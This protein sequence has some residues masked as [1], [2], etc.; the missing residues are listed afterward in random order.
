MC[1][2]LTGS[3]GGDHGVVDASQDGPP[4]NPCVSPV[5][6]KPPS[7]SRRFRAANAYVSFA[8]FPAPLPAIW[9]FVRVAQTPRLRGSSDS[10]L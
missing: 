8:P 6:A 9:A 2:L 4:C 7:G 5:G 3:A 10:E 1:G